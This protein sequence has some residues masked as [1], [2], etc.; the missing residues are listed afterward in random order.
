MKTRVSL[1]YLVN[2]CSLVLCAGPATQSLLA[3]LLCRLAS[4]GEEVLGNTALLGTNSGPYAYACV[5]KT[6]GT[7]D[8]S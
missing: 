4:T 6:E 3:V 7:T 2:D 5:G 8:V 1:K